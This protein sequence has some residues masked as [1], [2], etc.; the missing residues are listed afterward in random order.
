MTLVLR[1]MLKVNW[2]RQNN[3]FSFLFLTQVISLTLVPYSVHCTAKS[4]QT[5]LAVEYSANTNQ[6]GITTT[7]DDNFQGQTADTD[8]KKR[9]HIKAAHE[10][11]LSLNSLEPQTQAT[12]QF[13]QT[14]KN[15]IQHL[16]SCGS[17]LG[18]SFLPVSTSAHHLIYFFFLTNPI[19]LL[20]DT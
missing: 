18:N 7:V 2:F 10:K 13:I 12:K 8:E 16:D 3:F 1:W 5:V 17:L 19:N 9:L 6:V 14:R 4:R 15:G 20:L 11:S